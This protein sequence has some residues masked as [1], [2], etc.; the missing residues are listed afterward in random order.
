MPVQSVVVCEPCDA[1][2]SM[3]SLDLIR[4]AQRK[5]VADLGT[6]VRSF[7]TTIGQVTLAADDLFRVRVETRDALWIPPD[8]KA[9]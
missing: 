4:A 2:D 5:A 9:S 1:D 7:L 8:D 3:P 6:D